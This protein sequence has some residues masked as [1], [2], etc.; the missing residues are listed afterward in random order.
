MVEVYLCDRKGFS[1]RLEVMKFIAL[2]RKTS[3]CYAIVCFAMLR[4]VS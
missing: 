4:P 2:K 3:L 1:K